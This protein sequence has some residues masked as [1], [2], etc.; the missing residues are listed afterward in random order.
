MEDKLRE[1]E[2]IPG[3][4]DLSVSRQRSSDSSQKE[5]RLFHAKRDKIRNG[6]NLLKYMKK[7][8]F[9][10]IGGGDSASLDPAR[11]DDGEA[12]KVI[13]NLFEG[14]VRFQDGSTEVEPALAVSWETSADG[15]EWTFHLREGV[16]FHDGTPFDADAVV[17]SFMR[18][19]DP[20]HPF[21]RKDFAN[22]STFEYVRAV[23]AVDEQTLRILLGK[24]YAPFLYNLAEPTAAPIISPAALKKWGDDFGKHPMGT[25]PFK[26]EEWVP[27]DRI[28]LF[29]N[30]D[31]WGG[32]PHLDRL[33]FKT[34]INN[35]S[36]LLSLSTGSIDG[37]DGIDPN[38][39]KK[40]RLDK[41]LKF[42]II[43][44][45]NVGYL[46]MNTEKPPFDQVK[47]RQAVNHAIN[48][49]NLI[50]LLYQNL[51][52][53][54]KNSI[55]PVVW[56]YNDDIADYE[57]NRKRA[58]ALLKEAGYEKG[59]TTTLWAMPVPRPYMPQPEKIARA[60]KANL[61]AVGIRA[62]IVT[63]EWAAY[64]DKTANGE[65]DM[66]LSGAIAGSGDPYN[67]LYVLLDKDNA[68]KPKA[69]NLAFFKDEGLH[70]ILVKAQQISEKQE[71]IRLYRKAQE[72]IHNQAPWVPLAHA[73]QIIGR[74]KEVH[75]VVQHPTGF[76]RFH[77]AWIE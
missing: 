72:I 24:F 26:F 18:Q 61:A 64:I 74:R 77:K 48:K 34:I 16:T 73:Q 49:R 44:G 15:K 35:K 6:V 76:L 33:V 55:P 51:A 11:T 38:A 32:P 58:K 12:S 53:P 1:M 56:G 5:S 31:Y 59:F 54:A 46:A 28:I 8:R 10:R 22:P 52:I 75:D 62:E 60:I 45:L 69:G 42:E 13:A 4:W 63:H 66:C 2:G 40:I 25:G 3:R 71:R 9:G 68:V 23:K 20:K 47:V 41:A 57:Y 36:R 70:E 29:K 17:F 21:Y 65:H 43:T 27:G 67:F 19:I 7:R 37:M 50:K 14:L 39:A 30:R